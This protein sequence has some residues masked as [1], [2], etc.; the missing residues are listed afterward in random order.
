MT[1]LLPA[2]TYFVR[3]ARA[4]RRVRRAVVAAH[5]HDRGG[6]SARDAPH[7]AKGPWASKQ[8]DCASTARLPQLRAG[9]G[10]DEALIIEMSDGGAWLPAAEGVKGKTATI[11]SLDPYS[12]YRFRAVATNALGTS[13]AGA[14]SNPTLTDPEQK[15]GEAPTVTPTSSASFESRG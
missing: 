1:G 11:A 15:L 7:G 8:R 13:T 12:A 14:E 2:T 10:G 6:I 9:C 5:R 4:R 3:G